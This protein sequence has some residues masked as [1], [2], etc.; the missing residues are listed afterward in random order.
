M[1]LGLPGLAVP[2]LAWFTLR[3]PRCGKPTINVASRSATSISSQPEAAALSSVHPS[4]REVRGP[5]GQ[6]HFPPLVALLVGVDFLGHGIGQWKPAFFVR[7]DGLQTGEPGTWFSLIYGIGSVVGMYCGGEWACRRAANDERLQLKAMA[8]AYCCF[9]VI[10]AC[11]F[12]SPDL[13]VAR[14]T[15]APAA[16]DYAARVVAW[17]EAHMQART[18]QQPA[19]G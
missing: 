15:Q 16:M 3:D 10:S 13:Q 9:A 14:S 11:I 6:H 8:I 12:L 19:A 1:L 5:V 4:L 2:A 18:A 17:F 7:S